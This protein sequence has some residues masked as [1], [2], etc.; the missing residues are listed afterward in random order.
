[1]LFSTAVCFSDRNNGIEGTFSEFPDDTRLCRA[2]DMLDG[3]DATQSDFG[4]LERWDWVNIMKCN[5]SK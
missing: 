3:R 2:G 5:Q 4:R 1:M